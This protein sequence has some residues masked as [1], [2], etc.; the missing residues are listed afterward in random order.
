MDINPFKNCKYLVAEQ[1]IKYAPHGILAKLW[2][3]DS[4]GAKSM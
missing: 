4:V 2:G 1:F 3:V